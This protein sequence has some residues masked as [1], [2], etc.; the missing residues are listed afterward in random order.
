M[1]AAP[2]SFGRVSSWRLWRSDRMREPAE[3]GRRAAWAGFDLAKR[4][5]RNGVVESAEVTSSRALRSAR[6]GA[7]EPADQPPKA[8]SSND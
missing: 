8:G 5:G 6:Q 2:R 7:C 3:E 1:S 4:S